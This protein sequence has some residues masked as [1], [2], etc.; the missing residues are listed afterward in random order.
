MRRSL[1]FKI[2]ETRREPTLL[3]GIVFFVFN[4]GQGVF[5][6]VCAWVLESQNVDWQNHF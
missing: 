5:M 3:A 2:Q 4:S 6:V 1:A